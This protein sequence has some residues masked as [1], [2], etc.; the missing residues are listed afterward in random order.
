[1][2]TPPS[3]LQ[4][5]VLV[6]FWVVILLVPWRGG[7][8]LLNTA[9]QGLPRNDYGQRWSVL[10]VFDIPDKNDPSRVYLK[11]LRILQTPWF[12]F[13][14][15]WVYLPDSDRDPHDHPWTFW[16]FVARGGYTEVLTDR[17][18]PLH[19]RTHKRW[20]LHQMPTDKAH[21]ISTLLGPT[22]TVLLVGRRKRDWGF[23]TEDGWVPWREYNAAENGPDPFMS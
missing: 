2:S 3:L 17:E 9:L 16:S 10:R 8:S 14:I 6:L 21:K 1:M 5:L 11:R 4:W 13:Y 20:S 15:H 19:L 18:H 12:G 7:G 22:I 23:W